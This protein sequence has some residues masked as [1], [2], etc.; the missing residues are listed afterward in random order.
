MATI[1]AMARQTIRSASGMGEFEKKFSARLNAISA[2]HDIVMH[3]NQGG[4]SLQ[5]MIERQIGPYTSDLGAQVK[6]GGQD[7]E[8]SGPSAHAIGLV[9]HELAT[10]AA[11]Y[12]A[13]SLPRSYIEISW[14]MP[15]T[16]WLT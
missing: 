6:L 12:G 1:Q 5:T 9:L 10:N 2:A 16:A 4:A 8:L 11:K 3:Q 15:L 13:L 7:V 14:R